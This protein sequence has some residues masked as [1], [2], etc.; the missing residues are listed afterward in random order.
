MNNTKRLTNPKHVLENMNKDYK[1][2]KITFDSTSSIPSH[3]TSHAQGYARYRE[4]S[5]L[6]GFPNISS[7]MGSP[8]F[9]IFPYSNVAGKYGYV[10]IASE[11]KDSNGKSKHFFTLKVP[12]C[13]MRHQ[14]VAAKGSNLN[15][16]FNHPCGVQVFGDYLLLPV[17]PFHTTNMSFYDSAIVYLYDLSSL[18]GSTPKAPTRF[19]EI[20][21]VSKVNG[22]SLSCVGIT[23][24]KTGGFVLGLMT[25]ANLDL[26]FT[27]NTPADLWDAGWEKSPKLKY[28][29]KSGDGNN[30]YQGIGFFGDEKDD[31]Y[32]IGFD[33]RGGISKK[34]M[35]D[36][37]ILTSNGGNWRT[38]TTLEP[39]YKK[40]LTGGQ[41]ARFSYGGGIEIQTLPAL[42]I[43]S[44]ESKYTNKGLR[45][46]YWY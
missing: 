21:R 27:S 17:I 16:H 46:N 9:H 3:V 30:H 39:M 38:S 28:K 18:K 32:M 15:P 14:D 11:Q 23:R 31:I 6:S 35:A 42:T 5:G 20:L 40:H 4:A 12:A 7:F 19:K 24:L 8:G 26:Y 36:M 37:Y 13:E 34:D 25:D 10:Y 22:A 2:Q 1:W 29:L 33:T 43:Y 45:I 44:V 41:G